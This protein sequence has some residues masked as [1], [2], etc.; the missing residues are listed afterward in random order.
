MNRTL[1]MIAVIVFV[2]LLSACNTTQK[3]SQSAPEF[4]NVPFNKV[5]VESEQT[6][7]QL[8]D[9]ITKKLDRYVQHAETKYEISKKMLEFIFSSS[10][11]D[12]NYLTGATLSANDTFNSQN[13]NCLSL[14]IMANSMANHLGLES[15]FQLVNIPEY[16]ASEQGYNLLTGHVNLR[17]TKTEKEIASNLHYD[18]SKDIVIDFNADMRK[19]RF[20]TEFI[21]Q[22]T[23]TAM[24][25]NNKGAAAMIDRNFDLAYSYFSA[26]IDAE[27]NFSGSYANLGVLFRLVEQLDNA[28]KAY[29]HA[30]VINNNATAQGNLAILFE[31]TGREELAFTIRRN[32]EKKRKSNPYYFIA[33][34]NDAYYQKDFVAAIRLYKKAIELDKSIHESH[35]GL[36]KTY[37]AQGR[38]EKARQ[39]LVKAKRTALFDSDKDRYQGK[40]MSLSAMRY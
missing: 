11:K 35:F 5:A 2:S 27:P 30:I 36:A 16:W 14:S 8:D 9:T 19:Q 40:I 29:K 26:A 18:F 3:Q 10:G 31:M 34:G 32:L 7:Y 4:S 39:A 38:N 33:E 24:F 15:R 37:F 13:A 12:L 17:V 1:H 20:S 28:E 21:S 23:I 22:D 25:Y 6:I